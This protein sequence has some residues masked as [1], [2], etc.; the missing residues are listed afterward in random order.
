VPEDIDEYLAGLD[1]TKRAT[2]QRLRE[3]ILA[4]APDA[5]EGISYGVPAFRVAGKL[6]AG[7]SAAS[8]HL[9]YLPHSGSVLGDLGERDAAVLAGYD[10]SKGALRFAVD[11]PLPDELVARLVR[12]RRAEV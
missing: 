10:V 4:V 12:A 9:S 3:S 6:V 5:E 1:A 2:L 11:R 7:F 8:E